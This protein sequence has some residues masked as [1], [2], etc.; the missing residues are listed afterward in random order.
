M[1]LKEPYMVKQ[2]WGPGNL[3]LVADA[4]ESLLIKNVCVYSPMTEY[5]LFR[6]GK[7][8]VGYFRVLGLLGGHLSLMP[9]NISHSHARIIS[10]TALTTPQYMR[11]IDAY[12]IENTEHGAVCE[13]GA[14]PV[15]ENAL[16]FERVTPTGHKT[17]LKLLW[18]LNI[19]KG[20]PVAEGQKFVI[21]GV[22]GTGALQLVEYEVW[23]AGDKTPDMENGSEA[24]EYFFVNYGRPRVTI[25]YTGETRYEVPTSPPEFPD[26][27]FGRSFSDIDGKFPLFFPQ[28]MRFAAG[29]GLG[30]WLVTE[31]GPAVAA[32]PLGPENVEIGLIE[33]VR[34][35]A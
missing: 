6:I 15:F 20:Y 24:T 16:Q 12:G 26:F 8:T 13:A 9:G 30:V 31:A 34:K 1:A 11:Q 33:K 32:S 2:L 29:E 22:G 25:N 19:F 21:E 23:D 7:A 5:A 18:D 4:G 28:P 17:L 35:V 27:P 14:G 3:E 10:T